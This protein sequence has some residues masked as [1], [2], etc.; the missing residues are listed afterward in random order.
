MNRNF[1][2]ET[3]N[4]T[5]TAQNYHDVFALLCSDLKKT[6]L[7][8]DVG[9]ST[10]DHCSNV[11]VL[12]NNGW[13][14][15]GFDLKPTLDACWL[16]YPNMQAHCLEMVK[17][18]E[19]ANSIIEKMPPIVDY[20]NV[21]LDGFPAQYVIEKINLKSRKYRCMTIEHDAYRFGNVFKDAQRNVLLNNG[22]EIVITTAAEDWYVYPSLIEPEYYSLLKSIPSQM[23]Y[24]RNIHDI[25]TFIG[26]GGIHEGPYRT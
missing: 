7:F 11:V 6:G 26:F 14:G 3:S 8:I 12:L 2:S 22:Y 13:S 25:K 16:P 15:V 21:D 24:D 17:D 23:I 9:C 20:L 10:P 5:S 1:I 4:L 19:V 18:W